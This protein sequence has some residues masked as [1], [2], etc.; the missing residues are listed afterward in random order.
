[1]CLLF[2]GQETILQTERIMEEFNNHTSGQ[3][4]WGD[5]EVGTV[6]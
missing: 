1:M 2:R 4:G 5:V 3:Q 6:L